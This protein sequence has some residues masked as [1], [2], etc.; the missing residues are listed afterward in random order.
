MAVVVVAQRA[1]ARVQSER[2]NAL[3]SARRGVLRVRAH[4]FERSRRL[5]VP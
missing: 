1:R 4:A 5:C 3:A 2:P